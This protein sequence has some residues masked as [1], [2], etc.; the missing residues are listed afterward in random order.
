MKV[1]KKGVVETKKEEMVKIAVR[2]RGQLF[3]TIK[4]FR[5]EDDDAEEII[6]EVLLRVYRYGHTHDKERG[7]SEKT[8]IYQTCQQMCWHFKRAKNAQKRTGKVYSIEEEEINREQGTA[9]GAVRAREIES[10][11]SCSIEMEKAVVA[12]ALIADIRKEI[13][14]IKIDRIRRITWK[15]VVEEFSQA[16]L[17]EEEKVSRAYI[18]VLVK[19]GLSSVYKK[20]KHKYP[21]LRMDGLLTLKFG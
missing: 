19:K 8:W 14:K 2:M 21:D 15:S 1:S 17:A 20:L 18:Q 11:L 7:Q 12:K 16:Q 13:Q 10:S 3:K 5:I 9:N 4:G 6:Q